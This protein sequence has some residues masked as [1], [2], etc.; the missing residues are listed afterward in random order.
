MSG[1]IRKLH[2][3]HSCV[4]ML[5]IIIKTVASFGQSGSNS[6]SRTVEIITVNMRGAPVVGKPQSLESTSDSVVLGGFH[7]DRGCRGN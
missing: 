3:V 2:N 6:H 5:D 4:A 7:A 1:V